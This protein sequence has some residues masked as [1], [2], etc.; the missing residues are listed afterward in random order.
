PRAL[1]PFGI[2]HHYCPLAELLW[3]GTNK[4][5]NLKEDCRKLFQPLTD[6]TLYYVDG[7]GQEAMPGNQLPGKLQVRVG[8]GQV[9]VG[10][11][12]VVFSILLG[13][14]TLSGPGVSSGVP[15]KA[16][17]VTTEPTNGIADCSWTLDGVTQFQQVE[18]VLLD[19]S[20][21][22]V[23]G[24]VRFNANLSVASQVAYTP[25]AGC[26]SLQGAATV[27]TALDDLAAVTRIYYVGGGGQTASAA[28]D[29]G[30]G[31][32]A[33]A[34]LLQVAVYSNCGAASGRTVRFKIASGG[35]SLALTK[36][37]AGVLS[38]DVPVDA[39]TGVAS[40]AWSIDPTKPGSADPAK[41]P[42]QVEARLLDSAA[43]ELDPPVHF[44][45]NYGPGFRVNAVSLRDS[46]ANLVPLAN[47][48]TIKSNQLGPGITVQF[49][50]AVDLKMIT[51]NPV[52]LVR[53]EVPFPLTAAERDT[54]GSAGAGTH[55]FTARAVLT[56]N[57]DSTQ[58]L[59]APADPSHL[60]A[61]LNRVFAQMS[62]AGI[63]PPLLARFIL[64]G[65]FITS[66]A[67]P[68]LF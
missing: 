44:T 10:N 30:T 11:A 38:L 64:K 2:R 51:G 68:S 5:F 7:D 60:Q 59:W 12:K 37:A 42:Y 8:R 20:G 45:A 39:T 62:L 63:S 33:L 40:C 54:W 9:P 1:A 3:D 25:P 49:S 52:S 48:S 56:T 14:G 41:P 55:P 67:D 13:N 26:A 47:D 58:L 17:T 61:Y 35:G 46:S 29:P 34:Q 53:I 27:Q 36:G 15:G 24:P 65:N 23:A 16:L 28:P 6:P 50:Q 4:V 66:A 43:K 19:S 22:Q 57:P 31:L 21:V 32:I 18:A